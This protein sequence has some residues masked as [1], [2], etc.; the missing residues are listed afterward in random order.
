MDLIPA[1]AGVM[2]EDGAAPRLE[3]SASARTMAEI[4]T[5]P[6]V[7]ERPFAELR[8]VGKVEVDETRVAAISAWVPGR[9]D[10]LYVD[11]TGSAVRKGDHLAE[12]YS[13]ELLSAQQELL[14]AIRTKGAT[15]E[16]GSQVLR[17]SADATVDAARDKLRLLGLAPGQ[18]DRLA[19][20]GD[21]SDHVT[22]YAHAGGVV[23]EKNAVEGDYVKTGAVIYR[24]AD[25]SHLWVKLDAYESDLAWLR[26]GQGVEFTTEAVPGRVFR[27]EVT[28]ISPMLDSRTRTSKVRVHVGNED[29]LLKPE[30]FVHATVHAELGSDG[31]V[32][33]EDLAGKWICPMH[34]EVV[35]DKRG[36]CDV[37]GMDLERAED[38]GYVTARDSGAGSLLIPRTAVLFTGKRAV[39]Y[40]EVPDADRPTY[41]G[42]QIALGPR[43][44]D[45]YV[46]KEGLAEGER[47]VTKGNF[48]IDSALQIQAKPS[49]MSPPSD[50]KAGMEPGT[51]AAGVS[52][53]FV[54]TLTPL[55][56]AYFD[57]ADALAADDAAA[58]RAAYAT[59]HKA[60]HEPEAARL[61]TRDRK[62]WSR[63]TKELMTALDAPGKAAD[64]DALRDSF[65]S[66]SQSVLE[67]ERRFGHAGDA[68]FY[69]TFCPMAF[70]GEGAQWMQDHEQIDNP[71]YGSRM[72][73]CGE[74]QQEL[75]PIGGK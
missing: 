26:Y 12:V 42:R 23:V 5:T 22:L 2:D 32:V 14:Q 4:E 70:Q 33:A 16:S 31:T 55:Y 74:V 44:G 51:T 17:G 45:R 30:M 24:I 7:R 71:F 20:A 60:M 72:L 53:A 19:A 34:P 9:L 27:G 29:G 69:R 62:E 50:A 64:L 36:E 75:A 37:C 68:V 49:M 38:L 46:V 54:A 58:A 8:L 47:V 57:L 25:L 43:A 40:V 35:R 61:S 65:G 52:A 59:T 18:I 66:V 11:Y 6:V 13:P 73:R 41:E 28:F 48:K 1:D 3:M 10:R 56:E 63:V 21:A 67:I 39:V 15:R